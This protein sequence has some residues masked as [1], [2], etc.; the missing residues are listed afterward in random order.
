MSGIQT[1]SNGNEEFDGSNPPEVSVI[2]VTWNSRD[3]LSQCLEDLSRQV[4]KGYELI[5]VDNGSGDTAGL[6]LNELSRIFD[7]RIERLT[8]NL[9]FAAANNIG[10]RLARGKWLALLNADAFPESDW[11]A[12]LVKA[13]E[14][15]PEF[16]FF[17][18]RQIQA[19][20][21]DLLDG[22]GDMYHVSGL[23]WRR[24]YNQP[25]GS[26]GL[27]AEEVFGACAAAAL[28]RREDFLRVGGFDESYFSYYEDVDL[29]FRL[30]LAGGRCLYVPEAVVHHVGSASTGRASD[31][32]YYY[33]HRNLVWTFFKN[34]PAPLLWRHLINHVLVNLYLAIR[35]LIREKRV[36][37]LKAKWDA[38][39]ALPSILRQRRQ[40][41]Q[42]RLADIRDLYRVMD[43]NVLVLRRVFHTRT[44]YQR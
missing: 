19:N 30:R 9:G 31:F 10:A 28:Y 7:L 25:A 26:N 8:S 13:A 15:N 37:V 3:T 38:L 27:H 36:V 23:S 35:I 33:V 39:C 4:F 43:K 11:L 40:V 12:H 16:T 2:L 6:N 21:P 5:I 17:T 34:M 24:H 32:S 14:K 20:M 42:M 29:S 41:Q 18:S 1:R 22:T 44:Q